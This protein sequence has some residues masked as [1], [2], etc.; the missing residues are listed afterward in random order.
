MNRKNIINSIENVKERIDRVKEIISEKEKVID[1]LSEQ[2]YY[3]ALKINLVEIGEESKVIND[4]L[5][6]KEDD[7][8]DIISKEYHFKISLTHYYK[9]MSEIK[10]DKHLERDFEKFIEKINELEKKYRKK[11]DK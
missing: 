5:L 8:D 1:Y 6:E 10:I 2:Y 3:E 11:E 7:W 4:I 9:N